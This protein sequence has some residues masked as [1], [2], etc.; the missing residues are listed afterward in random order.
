MRGCFWSL[1]GSSVPL[2]LLRPLYSLYLCALTLSLGFNQRKQRK[3]FSESHPLNAL[4]PAK[5]SCH[6]SPLAQPRHHQES[7]D[8]FP[9]NLSHIHKK[10]SSY[11]CFRRILYYLNKL[12]T[13]LKELPVQRQ[14]SVLFQQTH[15]NEHF[16][17]LSLKSKEQA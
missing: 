10:I 5:V 12:G 7:K 8:Y 11:M 9:S 17:K 6:T 3:F 16:Q 14:K 1:E 2:V 15:T 13:I 4:V